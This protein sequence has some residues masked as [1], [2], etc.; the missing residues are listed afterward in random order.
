MNFWQQHALS[1]L[2]A[3]PFLSVVRMIGRLADI[4]DSPSIYLHSAIIVAWA[5]PLQTGAAYLCMR[6]LPGTIP[7]SVRAVLGCVIVSPALALISPLSSWVVGVGPEAIVNAVTRDEVR[8]YLAVRYPYLLSAFA[9]IGPAIW[10]ALNFN[11]WR[12]EFAWREME[13][14][15]S[16]PSELEEEVSD[17]AAKDSPNSG[18]DRMPLFVSKLPIG[19]Q[20]RLY[21]LTSE[22]HYV[23][24]YTEHGDD[25]VLMR[26]SDAIEQTSGID[27]L[28]I[29]RSHWIAIEAVKRISN[30]GGGLRITLANDLELPVSR[31]FQGAVRNALPNLIL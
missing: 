20:G 30:N 12:R 2:I 17:Q 4:G 25:L 7:L 28:Q 18:E 24:V 23:R 6:F 26:F 16:A 27:G 1:M 8:M 29:H 21:A 31:S 11:W 9:V 5:T 10:M 3:I 22:L 15:A 14:A 19:K 13:D